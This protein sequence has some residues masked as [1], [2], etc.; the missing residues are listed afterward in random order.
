MP[1]QF[2]SPLGASQMRKTNKSLVKANVQ[3]AFITTVM[4]QKNEKRNC[5]KEESIVC[6]VATWLNSSWQRRWGSW[7]RCCYKQEAEIDKHFCPTSCVFSFSLGSSMWN[8]AVNYVGMWRARIPTRESWSHLLSSC[9]RVDLTTTG[10]LLV[11]ILYPTKS[12]CIIKMRGN[13]GCW[14]NLPLGLF[15]YVSITL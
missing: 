3:I 13:L 9:K 7:S 12:V 5:S 11:Q 14:Y 4:N 8:V 2:C 15:H 10:S 1:Q 6:F